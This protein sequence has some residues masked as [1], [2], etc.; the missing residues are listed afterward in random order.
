MKQKNPSLAEQ[1]EDEG[2]QSMYT[3][4][5]PLDLISQRYQRITNSAA[6]AA[7]TASGMATNQTTSLDGPDRNYDSYST[8]VNGTADQ[9]PPAGDPTSATD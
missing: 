3:S 7:T 4:S 2:V 5:I 6:V 8:S 1:S 9:P